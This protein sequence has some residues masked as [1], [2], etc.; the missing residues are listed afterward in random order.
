MS[1]FI[2]SALVVVALLGSVSTA[3]AT[4]YGYGYGKGYSS[5]KSYGRWVKVGGKWKFE[6]RAFF[7]NL[8]KYGS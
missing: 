1:T 7:D 5:G 8:R 4:Y 2:R 6:T 3:S